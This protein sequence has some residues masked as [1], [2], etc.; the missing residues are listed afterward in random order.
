[1]VNPA[2]VTDGAAGSP[3]GDYRPL[4]LRTDSRGVGYA[5]AFIELPAG[6][7]QFGGVMVADQKVVADRDFVGKT[8]SASRVR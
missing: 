4:Q 6:T 2:P 7:W 8:P 3:T 1:M 5:T